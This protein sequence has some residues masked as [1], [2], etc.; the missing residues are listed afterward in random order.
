MKFSKKIFSLLFL[1]SLFLGGIN[2]WAAGNGPDS[3]LSPSKAQSEEVEDTCATEL[4]SVIF[5]SILGQSFWDSKDQLLALYL[6]NELHAKYELQEVERLKILV[7]WQKIAQSKLDIILAKNDAFFSNQEL[8]SLKLA[9]LN[10]SFSLIFNTRGCINA[11]DFL[12]DSVV[13]QVVKDTISKPLPKELSELL[14]VNFYVFWKDIYTRY[15]KLIDKYSQNR[16]NLTDLDQNFKN[17]LNTLLKILAL[18][19][20]VL[21]PIKFVEGWN[22]LKKQ[23]FGPLGGRVE[24]LV[25]RKFSDLENKTDA[26]FKGG[27]F[28]AERMAIE[29]QLKGSIKLFDVLILKLLKIKNEMN[30]AALLTGT[31]SGKNLTKKEIALKHLI[32]SNDED[33]KNGEFAPFFSCYNVLIEEF[34]N[35]EKVNEDFYF[36]LNQCLYD[37]KKF[38][39]QKEAKGSLYSLGVFK[40]LTA[41][42]ICFLIDQMISNLLSVS[43]AIKLESKGALGRS[44]PFLEKLL[45]GDIQIPDK[46]TKAF[47][48]LVQTVIGT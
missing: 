39:N 12:C 25:I 45:N 9:L 48:L 1:G 32:L 40:D 14:N 4:N 34:L 2:L 37:L 21:T 16:G 27:Y 42:R 47:E 43:K 38:K 28:S 31:L 35:K 11:Q 22:K 15:K 36:R 8:R 44:E 33:V 19:K 29:N 20:S 17:E 10:K 24:N 3:N 41:S 30:A 26:D 5:N 7:E 6:D 46:L 18:Q 13:A 23:L